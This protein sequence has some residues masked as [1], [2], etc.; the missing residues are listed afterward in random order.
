MIIT[1]T[2]TCRYICYSIHLIRLCVDF[3]WKMSNEDMNWY[4]FLIRSFREKATN[5]SSR[6]C[7]VFAIR[8]INIC[9]RFE[10]CVTLLN[11]L[12]MCMSPTCWV[13]VC[14]FHI[15]IML[16]LNHRHYRGI[17]RPTEKGVNAYTAHTHESY[18]TTT[19]FQLNDNIC[20]RSVTKVYGIYLNRIFNM[21]YREWAKHTWEFLRNTLKHSRSIASLSWLLAHCLHLNQFQMS[22]FTMM[23][24]NILPRHLHF[25]ILCTNKMQLNRT[26]SSDKMKRKTFSSVVRAKSN[27]A[28]K[29]LEL[30]FCHIEVKWGCI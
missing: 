13:S 25:S 26:L 18:K 30:K 9:Y 14:N 17:D 21:F 11:M 27:Y 2:Y 16:P 1:N 24:A 6:W 19:H 5:T 12:A 4:T 29:Y 20:K 22:S 23:M 3:S 15:H 10:R 8:H 28:N 7:C